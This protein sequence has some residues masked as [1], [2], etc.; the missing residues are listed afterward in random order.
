[1]VIAERR[2]EGE[3]RTLQFANYVFDASVE[4]IFNTLSSGGCLCMA[5]TAMMLDDLP[6]VIAQLRVRQAI[7]TPTVA[8]LM[9]PDQVRNIFT[10]VVMKRF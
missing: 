10:L 9:T 2:F 1:M 6:S 7:L 8:R 5:P 3:W 4:D